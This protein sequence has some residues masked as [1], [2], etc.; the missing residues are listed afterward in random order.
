VPTGPSTFSVSVIIAARNE[1]GNLPRCLKSLR[2]AGE[3]YDIDSESGLCE[4]SQ[5]RYS[6]QYPPERPRA[7]NDRVSQ[8]RQ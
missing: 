6:L 5:E 2:G 4:V 7:A 1:A 3:V 8:R